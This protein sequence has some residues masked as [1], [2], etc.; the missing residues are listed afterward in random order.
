MSRF[1]P[2]NM[3]FLQAHDVNFVIVC[4]NTNIVALGGWRTLNIQLKNSESRVQGLEVLGQLQLQLQ[5][6]FV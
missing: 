4:Y 1:V 6:K 3:I 2:V 5:Y